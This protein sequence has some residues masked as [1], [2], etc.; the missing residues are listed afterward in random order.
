MCGN[1]KKM[2]CKRTRL[3]IISVFAFTLCLT[4]CGAN[5]TQD[6]ATLPL[7]SEEYPVAVESTDTNITTETTLETTAAE[8]TAE[9]VIVT[10][11]D[12]NADADNKSMGNVQTTDIT[13]AHVTAVSTDVDSW[14]KTYASVLMQQIADDKATKDKYSQFRPLNGIEMGTQSIIALI[15]VD[16]D[17]TPELFAGTCGTTGSGCFDVYTTNGEVFAKDFNCSTDFASGCV[18]DDA[19]YMRCGYS[20]VTGWVKLVQGT[21]SI[22]VDTLHNTANVITESGAVV[23]FENQSEDDIKA[24]YKQYLNVDYA[25]LERST[26]EN[27]YTVLRGHLAVPDPEN[28]TEE[29]I[30]NCL[31]PLLNEYVAQ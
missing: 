15:D 3:S 19:L 21:P 8:T 2:L 5:A 4:A 11:T 9:T 24:L 7:T 17:G 22:T 31:V 26:P 1:I 20:D 14:A 12:V 30:Y 25:A 28:Y 29:D 10:E 23:T 16:M 6:V 18:V 27:T 13:T